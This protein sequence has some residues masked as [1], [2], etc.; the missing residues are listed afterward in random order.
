M[1]V[2]ILAAAVIGLMVGAV[3]AW[4]H[5]R[6]LSATRLDERGRS[7]EAE[8][9]RLRD[10]IVRERGARAN[11]ELQASSERERSDLQLTGVRDQLAASAKEI[12]DLR[13]ALGKA[14]ERTESLTRE[15]AELRQALDV[16]EAIRQNNEALKAQLSAAQTREEERA[17][18]TSAHDALLT[19]AKEVLSHEFKAVSSDLLDQKAKH[20]NEQQSDQ[21]NLLLRPFREQ[22]DQFQKDVRTAK[23]QELEGRVELKGELKQLRDLNQNLSHEAH[24]LTQALRGDSKKR[25][26]WGELVLERLL[27]LAGLRPG[28]EFDIQPAVIGVDNQRQ[29]PDVVLRLSDERSVVIDS[30]LSLIAY[31]QLTASDS[32]DDRDKARKAH[33]AAMRTHIEQLSSKRYAESPDLRSPEF[34]VMFVPIEA[35]YLEAIADDDSLYEL[36]IS[37]RIIVASPGML[38][39]LLRIVNELWRVQE[40]QKNAEEIAR[41]A[42][43]L[44]D[45]FVRTAIELTNVDGRLAAAHEDLTKAIVRIQ[46]GRGN[47]LGQIEKLK[48]LGA[49]VNKSLPPVW[50]NQIETSDALPTAETG[51]AEDDPS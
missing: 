35:A 41:V 37:K 45:N 50:Q 28:R 47:M 42:G 23:E 7:H 46:S 8:L 44:Y 18:A 13:V 36:A 43:S 51:D 49:K 26:N 25:G 29:F 21:L 31:E 27:E 20:L 32:E 33:R 38:L 17:R 15:S 5:G 22:I 6:A 19:H 11:A 4:W 48:T 3:V 1:D 34:V 30:K 14:D 12:S 9:A 16:A 39:G 24:A 40:R 2:Q 10:E